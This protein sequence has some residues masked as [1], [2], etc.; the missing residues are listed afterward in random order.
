MAL[1]V[2]KLVKKIESVPPAILQKFALAYVQRYLLE[3]VRVTKLKSRLKTI[4]DPIFLYNLCHDL[5]ANVPDGG[6]MPADR[7]RKPSGKISR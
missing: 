2:A 1:V 3:A 6:A 5:I 4:N 7:F